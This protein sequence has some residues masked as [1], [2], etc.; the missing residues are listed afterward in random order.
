M[1]FYQRGLCRF[2]SLIDQRALFQLRLWILLG[3]V[4]GL[5]A[6]G[7]GSSLDRSTHT[8]ACTKARRT[9]PVD[10]YMS[11]TGGGATELEA[12]KAAKAELSSQISARL[13]SELTINASQSSQ[14]KDEQQV[15]Q[16]LKVSSSF[17][18]AELIQT[19]KECT[20][21]SANDCEAFVTL[22]RD[23]VASR[24]IKELGPDAERLT[25]ALKDLNLENSLL[26]FTPAWHVAQGSYERLRP[27]LNQ[28]EVIGRIPRT[29]SQVDQAMKRV[30]TTKATRLQQISIAIKPLQLVDATGSILSKQKQTSI[31]AALHE[32]LNASIEKIGL[33]TWGR[34][35]CPTEGLSEVVLLEQRA[36]LQCTLGYVGP[37]CALSLSVELSLCA[38]QAEPTLKSLGTAEWSAL[39]L[40]GVHPQDEN[41]AF[42]RL[43]ALITQ[44]EFTPSLARS[45]SPFVPF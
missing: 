19:I 6:C 31:E 27:Q 45:L 16:D 17:A 20:V 34:S 8:Q 1:I 39:K 35:Q 3:A 13:S 28:L 7:G 44:K 33:Q 4:L 36:V 26:A 15:T 21:C 40:V 38:S 18:H 37:Q 23:E 9:Y 42:K 14:G 5:N 12:I 11:A 43:V 29:L 22:D 32:R 25:T 41:E 2:E 24:M 30:Q 10:R